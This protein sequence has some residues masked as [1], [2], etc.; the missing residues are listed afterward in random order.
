M[1]PKSSTILILLMS[2]LILLLSID[3][4]ANHI[5][6]KVDGYYYDGLGQ[7]LAM[8]DVIPINASFNKIKS[9]LEKSMKF[10]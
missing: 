7:K 4:L 6:I 1:R 2:V 5:I 8:K 3:I 9:Q 10:H